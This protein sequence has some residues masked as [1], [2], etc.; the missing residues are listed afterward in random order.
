M[1]ATPGHILA[2]D[3]GTTNFKAAVFDPRLRR[4]AQAAAP[5]RYSSRGPGRVEFEAPA[6]WRL[7]A[8]LVG[9]VLARARVP[10]GA[11]ATVAITSQANTFCA[12]D[13]AGRPLTPF[14]SWRDR[15]AGAEAAWLNRRLGAAL[16]REA[17][18]G[19]L[20]AG[21][22]AAMLLWMRRHEPA[23]FRQAAVFVNLPAY[24]LGRLGFPPAVDANLAAMSGLYSLRQA[25]WW[26]DCLSLCGLIPARLPRL[27][28]LGGRLTP[29]RSNRLLPDLEQ[30]VLAGND[31]TAGAY[32]NGCGRGRL[33]ITLGTALV[34]YRCAGRRPGPFGP[35][36]SWGPYPGGGYYEL[37]ERSHGCAALDWAR[38]RLTPGRDI[39]AFLDLAQRAWRRRNARGTRPPATLFYPAC[40]GTPRAWAGSDDPADRALAV[41]EGIGFV[42][43]EML[44]HDLSDAEGRTGLVVVGGGSASA[45][46]RRV[47]ADILDRPV[48]R[49]RGDALLG[50]ARMDRP[51]RPAPAPGPCV[52]PREPERTRRLYEHWKRHTPT[53]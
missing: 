30:A 10:R 7:A 37:A 9:Q 25:A 20:A 31:Q 11:V 1:R 32:A 46:W 48:A 49:G 33:V 17:G 51:G 44:R 53:Q 39:A 22:Q 23:L 47:L 42:L 45:L 21:H 34:G 28:P 52:R 43:R 35:G 16:R 14:R 6:A 24:L 36:S 4:L 26:P 41:L 8:R 38:A 3:C 50:A 12:L 40:A 27:V 13:G 19:P 29:V 18:D 5:M 2:L 15:R